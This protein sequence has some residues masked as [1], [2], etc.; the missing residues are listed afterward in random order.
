MVI[1]L[2]L[3]VCECVCVCAFLNGEVFPVH[4]GRDRHVQLEY[5]PMGCMVSLMK[6]PSTALTVIEA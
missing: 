3:D 5:Q 2:C 6:E 1:C 4:A